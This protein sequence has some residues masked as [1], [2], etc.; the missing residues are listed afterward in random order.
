MSAAQILPYWRL[1]P[2]GLALSPCILNAAS[3]SALP[4]HTQQFPAL[5]L[6]RHGSCLR[7]RDKTSPS[8]GSSR[9]DRAMQR[10]NLR[11]ASSSSPLQEVKPCARWHSRWLV[12]MPTYTV[13]RPS[14][15]VAFLATPFTSAWPRPLHLC[16]SG[17]RRCD[18]WQWRGEPSNSRMAPVCVTCL[19]SMQPRKISSAS[20]A[21][22]MT[23]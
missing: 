17:H 16:C 13:V 3:A 4:P 8:A 21:S 20:T 11:S 2:L 6:S 18:R 15:V 5:L 19:Y 7:C 1:Y 14:H 23:W 22:T 9:G 12:H 10:S